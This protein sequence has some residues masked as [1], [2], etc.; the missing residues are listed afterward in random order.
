MVGTSATVAFLAR[1]PS[2]ARRKA[3][4]V[5]AIIGLRGILAQSVGAGGRRFQPWEGEGGRYQAGGRC[6]TQ[7]TVQLRRSLAELVPSIAEARPQRRRFIIKP[8][9][10]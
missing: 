5:R 10:Q 4:T 3:G 2:T 6:A 7:G 1:K 8:V 9:D